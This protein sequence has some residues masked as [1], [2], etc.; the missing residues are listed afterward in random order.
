[1][2]SV[3]IT[4]NALAP[5]AWV[6]GLVREEEV[7]SL[8]SLQKIRSEATNPLF[9]SEASHIVLG[10]YVYAKFFPIFHYHLNSFCS[11]RVASMVQSCPS[12][13]IFSIQEKK[14]SAG[15]G[16]QGGLSRG[17]EPPLGMEL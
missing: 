5:N 9:S 12:I 8:H 1:M 11:A 7:H 14:L 17:A 16:G 3:I 2:N 15:A 4:K 13:V 10:F 6:G